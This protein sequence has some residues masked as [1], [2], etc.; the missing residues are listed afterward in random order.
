MAGNGGSVMWKWTP[1][2]QV[3]MT[4]EDR[5][6]AWKH[7]RYAE[8]AMNVPRKEYLRAVVL[9][10]SGMHKEAIGIVRRFVKGSWVRR[11][12]DARGPQDVSISAVN[13]MQWMIRN[14]R[15]VAEELFK[16]RSQG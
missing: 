7:E 2:G 12:K 10:K 9:E 13:L 6:D 8:A 4:P 5:L 15:S 1:K 16:E 11:Y 14:K 3:L